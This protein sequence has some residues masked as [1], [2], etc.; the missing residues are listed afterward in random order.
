MKKYKYK[1]I[2]ITPQALDSIITTPKALDFQ[3]RHEMSIKAKYLSE[4]DFHWKRQFKKG[5]DSLPFM[6]GLFDEVF[7]YVDI[8]HI[9]RMQILA[10]SV[11]ETNNIKVK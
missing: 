1:S 7:F 10:K 6:A 5:I 4:T 2:V 8:C 11:G 9:W 3:I